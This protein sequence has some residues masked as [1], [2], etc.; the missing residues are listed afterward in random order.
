MNTSTVINEIELDKDFGTD[1]IRLYVQVRSY[2][3]DG[4][5]FVNKTVDFN[6]G[7]N[8]ISVLNVQL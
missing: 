1:R 7:G 6:N 5:H 4:Q 2:L 3:F 8:F